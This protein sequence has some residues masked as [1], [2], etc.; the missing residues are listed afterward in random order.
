MV[1][2]LAPPTISVE[3]A[4]FAPDYVSYDGGLELQSAA[5]ERIH[6]GADRGTII[7]LEHEP[8]YTAGRRSTPDEYPQ[9]GTPVVPVTRG[10]KVTWHGPGQLVV[11]PIVQLNER[12][13]VVDFVRALERVIIDAA[14]EIGAAGYRVPE[15]PGVW[16]DTQA[17]G[18][19]STVQAKFAQIGLHSSR[20]IITHGIAVNCSN[21]LAPFENFVPCGI[22]DA[23]VAT[24]SDLVGRTVTPEAFAPA[25]VRHMRGLVEEVAA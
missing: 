13:R 14:A 22:E 17:A 5:V 24:L 9:D 6:S 4:G 1:N 11:Y 2:L 10:G 21:D 15:F 12:Y 16:A 3:T 23:Q 18:A 19:H 25:L 20:R 7:V 8:V